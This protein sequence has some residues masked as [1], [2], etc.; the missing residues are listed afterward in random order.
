MR[1]Y[2]TLTRHLTTP[3]HPTDERLSMGVQGYLRRVIGNVRSSLN[4][5]VS[6]SLTRELFRLAREQDART[7]FKI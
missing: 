3:M 4:R 6:V 2:T 1:S 7:T 5:R